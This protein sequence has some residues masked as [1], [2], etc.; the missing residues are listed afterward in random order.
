MNTANLF[1]NVSSASSILS[2]SSSSASCSLSSSPQ[3]QNLM[4]MHTEPIY[5]KSASSISTESSP[6]PVASTTSSSSSSRSLI[7]SNH[8][9]D[10]HVSHYDQTYAN[11]S[12]E[13]NDAN[14]VNDMNDVNDGYLDSSISDDLDNQNGNN[15]STCSASNVTGSSCGSK[16]KTRFFSDDVVHVLKRWFIE[17]QDYP[18][19]DDIMTNMLAKEANISAKQVKKWFANKRVRSNKCFKQAFK[20]KKEKRINNRRQTVTYFIV[21]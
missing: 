17:N 10:E 14:D 16:K 4:M 6:S 18:Y 21:Y 3:Q 11:G 19:P 9:Y 5:I 7:N 12:N 1:Q 20:I 13:A 8:Q 15:I 2:T